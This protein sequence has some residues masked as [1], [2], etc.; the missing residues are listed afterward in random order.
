[1][2]EH[3]ELPSCPAGPRC[4]RTT[5]WWCAWCS[6]RAPPPG[7]PSWLTATT[8]V[9]SWKPKSSTS[10]QHTQRNLYRRERNASLRSLRFCCDTLK[11]FLTCSVNRN[12]RIDEKRSKSQTPVLA[13]LFASVFF[14]LSGCWRCWTPPRRDS[15]RCPGRHC[16]WRHWWPG[17]L[18]SGCCRRTV[19]GLRT[20]HMSPARPGSMARK[21]SGTP[22]ASGSSLTLLCILMTNENKCMDT[23]YGLRNAHTL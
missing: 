2:V 4:W 21:F 7:T 22:A 15:E 6:R 1:M 16:S 23:W 18:W 19:T 11:Y 5:S 17:T 9:R 8:T 13:S 10:K 3:A 14:F 12:R 20:R